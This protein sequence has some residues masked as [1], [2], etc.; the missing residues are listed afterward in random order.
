[1]VLGFDKLI[2]VFESCLNS[3]LFKGMA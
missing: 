1:V 2:C 3:R